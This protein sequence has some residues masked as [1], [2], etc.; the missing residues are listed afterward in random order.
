MSSPYPGGVGS[1]P[2][3]MDTTLANAG[4]L[5]LSCGVPGGP[6][7]VV[8]ATLSAVKVAKTN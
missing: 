4:T 3:N 1:A 5:T 7:H 2:L 6:M 8:E